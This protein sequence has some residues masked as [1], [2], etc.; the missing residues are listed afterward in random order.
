M[1]RGDTFY[2]ISTRFGV[3]IRE[4]QLANRVINPNALLIGQKLCIPKTG[5]RFVSEPLN[6]NFLY[7]INWILVSED[8]YEGVDGFFQVSAASGESLD[9]VCNNEAFHILRPYGSQPTILK[10]G[11]QGQEACV[12]FPYPDQP[13]EM[14]GQSALIVKYPSPITIS[15]QTYNFFILWADQ[16]H[17]REIANTVTFLVE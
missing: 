1:Q 14:R 17:I 13:P 3:S 11:I 5:H 7:P 8:R 6:V 4:L 12:I 2:S 15:G 10:I 16:N 9:Q